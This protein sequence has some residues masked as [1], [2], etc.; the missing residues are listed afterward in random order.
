MPKLIIDN[1]E[2]DVQPGTK[3]IDAA[4]QLGIMIPRFCYHPALGSVGACRVCAVKF[5]QGPFKGVQMSCMIDAK[6]GMV[7]STTDEEAVDFR[8]YVIEWL[9][10]HHPH[11]CPVCDEG[12]HCLLQDM[13]VAGG[14]GLRRYQGKKRTHHDQHLGPLVQHEMNRCIQCYRCSRFYQ[15]FSGYRDL[16]VLQIGERVY[17]GRYQAG[18]LE[19]PFSGNLIDICPT[20]VYTDKP[21]RFI[22]RRWDYERTPSLC[23]NCSLGCHTVVSTRYREIVRQEARF[24]EAVNGHFICDR[25]RYGFFYASQEKRPRYAQ[26]NGNEVSWEKSIQTARDQLNRISQESGPGAVASVG[27]VRSS[28]ET[29]AALSRLCQK[30]GWQGPVYWIDHG[31]EMNVK[32][33][34]AELADELAV[35]L[36][37]VEQADYILA[38]GADPVNEAPMLVLALR[39]AQR[40]GAKVCFLDPRPIGLPFSFQH[41]SVAP[42]AMDLILAHLLKETIDQ[43]TIKGLEPHEKKIFDAIPNNS[44]LVS[45]NQKLLNAV[46]NDIRLSQRLVIVCG[47]DVVSETIP[48]RAAYFARLLAKM[49]KQV[50]LFYLLPGAN[51]FGAAL[52]SDDAPTFGRILDEIEAG[53]V[54]ALVLVENDPYGYYPDRP[55]LERVLQQLDLLLV[56]DYLDVR[57]I[58]DAD[59]FL[60]TLT[61]YEAG[62]FFV[63][64][65]GR[66]QKA[67]I[68]YQGGH[69]ISQFSNGNHPP[70]SFRNQ[71]PGKEAQPAWQA[72]IELANENSATPK[73]G[74]RADILAWLVKTHPLF[75]KLPPDNAF[76]SDGIRINPGKDIHFRS[77]AD[78]LVVP[79]L[80]SESADQMELIT[81]D[82]TF[83]TEELSTR[84]PHLRK[85]ESKPCVFMHSNDAAQLDISEGDK[86]AVRS[87]TGIVSIHVTIT[88]N[89]APGVLI[90]PR[91]QRLDWQHLGASKI[92]VSKDQ[93]RKIREEEPC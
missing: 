2:I 92:T 42:Q 44:H 25:G 81:V 63:N 60:P 89:M 68:A 66:I 70:R 1:Q 55:R 53:L 56:M 76:P 7:V 78:R 58:Q 13:T 19:S 27:S 12:G 4:E 82:W 86:V 57:T 50:G 62:G 67:S 10:L 9:M 17:F 61:L 84:S 37:D 6:D 71:I 47:T 69:P 45:S 83:G 74:V 87:D 54:R 14:H 91:H 11:D 64:Q 39:Q 49:G 41:I 79:T 72:L 73:Q 46:A 88:D 3:V 29:Q 28:L 32:T 90:I 38:V 24:S 5:L 51:A 48:E 33:A 65:E 40:M 93:I 16:G 75:S 30:K 20:G 85:M 52:L 59:V 36:R 31:Q 8:K 35:S 15:K 23:I 80:A 34:A 18:T 21:S 22:G 43:D 26:I 77:A